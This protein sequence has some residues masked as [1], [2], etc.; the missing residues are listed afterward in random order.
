MNQNKAVKKLR[1]IAIQEVRDTDMD[2]YHS[3]EEKNQAMKKAQN[4]KTLNNFIDWA[5][6]NSWDLES[7]MGLIFK[8][9][10]ID[11]DPETFNSRDWDT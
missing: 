5:K 3:I 2:F 1:D 10:G 4:I 7:A 6:E 8:V 11:I 9:L